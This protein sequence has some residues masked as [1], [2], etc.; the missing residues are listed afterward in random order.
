MYTVKVLK[1]FC[2]DLDVTSGTGYIWVVEDIDKTY[3]QY[4]GYVW[5]EDDIS[6]RVGAKRTM[7]LRFIPIREGISTLTLAYKRPW[8]GGGEAANMKTYTF[9]II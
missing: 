7:R 4:V 3:I 8:D 9:N 6:D 2:I 5:V 1:P